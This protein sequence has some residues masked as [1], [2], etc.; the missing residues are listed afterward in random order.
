EKLARFALAARRAGAPEV[1]V[2]V[3]VGPVV[4]GV[5]AAAEELG[6][7]LIV[8]GTHGRTGLARMVLGSVAEGVVHRAHVPVMLV[9]REPSAACGRAS[10][11]WCAEDGQSPAERQV[12][13]EREG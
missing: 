8:M 5:L 3:E 7:D 11:E 13:A 10:C 12:L 4:D 6:A 9:R 1:D 2:A